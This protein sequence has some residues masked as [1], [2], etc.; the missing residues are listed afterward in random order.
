[1][2]DLTPPEGFERHFRRS[3]LT[4]PWEPLWSRRTEAG[5]SIGL[6]LAPAHTN[7]RGLAHGGLISAIADNAMGLACALRLG[8]EARLVTVNLSLDFLG[9][10]ALGQWIAWDAAVV[11]TG[12]TLCF[13]DCRVSADGKPSLAP[14]RPSAS[15]SRLRNSRI[16]PPPGGLSE[17][18]PEPA[19]HPDRDR[20]QRRHLVRQRRPLHVLRPAAPLRPPPAGPPAE[21]NA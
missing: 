6:H 4:D 21:L 10:A 15:A 14:T 12:R 16:D 11:K 7:S 5:F 19:H 13:A 18:A 17:H 9:V 20:R 8:G 3:P 2:T 1:V